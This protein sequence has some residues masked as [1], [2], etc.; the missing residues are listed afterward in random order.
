MSR[1]FEALLGMAWKERA[2][3][4]GNLCVTKLSIN[5]V[6]FPESPSCGQG[7]QFRPGEHHHLVA[8]GPFFE[9]T[10]FVAIGALDQRLGS[11]ELKDLGVYGCCEFWFSSMS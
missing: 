6:G 8:F 5:N 2:K 7:F 4:D 1:T 9:H 10:R 11:D 3:G